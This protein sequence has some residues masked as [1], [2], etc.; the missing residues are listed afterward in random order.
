MVIRA[1][2]PLLAHAV[3]LLLVLAAPA[4][5]QDAV[6]TTRLRRDVAALSADSMEGRAPGSRGHQRAADYLV[7]ALREIG[8]EGGAP[9]G[10]FVA[11][12]PLRRVAIERGATLRVE[13]PGGGALSLGLAE[14]HLMGRTAAAYRP[15]AGRVRQLGDARAAMAALSA[16]TT[17]RGEVA[18]LTA[19][20]GSL[21]PVLERLHALGAEGA[22]AL[23]PDSALYARFR[24][25][26]GVTRF[27]V[28]HDLGPDA[29]GAIPLA[30]VGPAG[31]AQVRQALG[32][33]AGAIAGT[34]PVP[35]DAVAGTAARIAISARV[36]FPPVPAANIIARIAGTS[37]ALRD[38]VV[39]YVAHYDHV[40]MTERPAPDSIF[41]G[42]VDNAT[43]V[44]AL[45]AIARAVRASPFPHGAVFLFVTAEEE[46]SLG[47]KF[48]LAA[49]SLL[50]TRALLA[51]NLDHPP[52]LGE[53]RAWYVE[54]KDDRTV[55]LV[56]AAA[57]TIGDSAEGLP[58]QPSSDHWSFMVRDIPAV[59]LVPGEGLAGVSPEQEQRLIER[60]WRPHRVDDEYD[61][62]FP[63]RGLAAM[64][65]LAW[66][67]GALGR[68]EP[69]R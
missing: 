66:R 52:P 65:E 7:R 51:I 8:A 45:L 49:D 57:R 26:R 1:S 55:Q 54:A 67:V 30:V 31:T 2:H 5:A 32:A 6:D 50:R 25:G 60:W 36:T 23:V 46:G 68:G 17:L 58:P 4:A 38:S 53:P 21:E 34:R 62:S 18:L 33:D 37:P 10:G 59:F 3:V 43:G 29:A 39:V 27:I 40:G 13:H 20:G 44:A 41:N 56:Q 12:I 19:G 63:V 48:Q 24:A 11:P 9:G 35:G 16:L 15:F 42:L 28:D 69:P 64:V 47:S 61:A 14:F 22:V